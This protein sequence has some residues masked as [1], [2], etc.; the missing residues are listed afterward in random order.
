MK[1]LGISAFYH[2]SASALIED[3]RIVS[4]T[5]E[6]RFNRKKHFAGFPELS[7]RDSLERGDIRLRDIDSIVFY[8]KP[9]LKFDR[10]LETYL[11]FAPEGF[12]SFRKSMP[13]W[14]TEKL[15]LKKK[16]L[17][18]LEGIEGVEN[19]SKK[20]LFAEHHMSHAASAFYPSPFNDAVVLTMDGVGEWATCSVAYGDQEKLSIQKEM[21]FPH[22]IGLLYSAFTYYTGFK[23]NSGEYKVMG[24]APYGTPKYA[25][26]IL[27]NIIDVKSDGSFR[28]NQDYFDYCTGLTMTNDRFSDLFGGPPRAPESPVTQKQMDLAASVQLVTEIVVDKIV[29]SLR[30]EFDTENICLAGGVALN[31]VANG[32]ILRK[33]YFRNMWIQ[34]AAGDAGGAVGSALHAYHSHH[35]K[36]R[37]VSDTDGMSGGYLG[38][39][40]SDSEIQ[41][42]LEKAGAT[43]SHL[44]YDEVLEKTSKAIA[45]GGAIGWFQ[46]RMEFGPRAL[47][48][49]SIIADPRNPEMQTALNLKIK[50]RE[51]FRPFAPAILRDDLSKWFDMNCDSPY[52]LLVTNLSKEK[53]VEVADDGLNRQ[54]FDKLKVKRSELP[55]ITHVDG[56]ARIQT[57]HEKTNPQFHD[58]INRFKSLTGCPVLINTSFNIRGEPIVCSPADAYRCFMG[59]GLDVLVV[60]NFYLEKS[61]QKESSYKDYKEQFDLD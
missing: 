20:I 22:S 36:P 47:G 14:L 19:L 4:A 17:E 45:G 7:I 23:V 26:R 50:F 9:I 41:A 44:D 33:R 21:H 2:D 46:G 42:A 32:K 31:C 56:S 29:S 43:F 10:L 59:T 40:Y 55:S 35:G 11:A 13:V 49:R 39:C 6:E 57:V 37:L 8:D 18:S 51:S 34:P 27:D 38:P 3:G 16:L 60:G 53:V 12:S 5:Q 58:L 15:F 54:G 25:D 61:Q 28:L 30:N 48:N 1:I 24:L 52:M